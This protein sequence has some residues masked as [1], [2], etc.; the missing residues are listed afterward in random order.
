MKGFYRYQFEH[1]AMFEQVNAT[2]KFHLDEGFG[3]LEISQNVLDDN[4]STIKLEGRFNCPVELYSDDGYAPAQLT[5][6]V[7]LGNCCECYME[8]LHQRFLVSP[9]KIVIYYSGEM[10]GYTRIHNTILSGISLNLNL[11]M[12]RQL[13][14]SD[15]RIELCKHFAPI[16]QDKA[17]PF[18]MLL[19]STPALLQT[20]QKI[21][22]CKPGNA[23]DVLQGRA[24]SW[25]CCADLIRT[26][27]HT[28]KANSKL[29]VTDVI[30]VRLARDILVDRMDEPPTLM[31][32]AREIGLNDFKLKLGFKEVFQQTAFGFLHHHRMEKAR[33]MLLKDRG[34]VIHV[35]NEVGYK[36]HGHFSVAFRK[37]FGITPRDYL[38]LTN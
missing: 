11:S 12:F 31:E 4:L 35:A 3:Q 21:A 33:D 19:D 34:N 20:A 27:M 9:G 37:H 5:I 2:G 1:S 8:N 24:L 15:G 28:S 16:L 26:L 18:F 23:C 36:N 14:E 38:K 22:A 10:S 17:K 32:L 29:S 6:F 13:I 7:N 25:Q 30:K